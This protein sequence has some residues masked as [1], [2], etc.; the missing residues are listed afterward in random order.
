MS[1]TAPP[2]DRAADAVARYLGP[3]IRHYGETRSPQ[4]AKAVA[5]QIDIMCDRHA[6]DNDVAER[7][8]YLQLRSHWRLLAMAAKPDERL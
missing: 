7:R 1:G 3:L 2:I 8:A 6:L 4:I 5:Q